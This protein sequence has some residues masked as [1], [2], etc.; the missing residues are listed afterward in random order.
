MNRDI[1]ERF[2]RNVE[3]HRHTPIIEGSDASWVVRARERSGAYEY[4]V[5]FS[6][7]EIGLVHVRAYRDKL[8]G[9]SKQHDLGSFELESST[10][11]AKIWGWMIGR[12]SDLIR[13]DRY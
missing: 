8:Q 9:A 13:A 3:R 10:D 2:A 7:D 6:Q 12:E 5:T 4:V 1:A 11:I